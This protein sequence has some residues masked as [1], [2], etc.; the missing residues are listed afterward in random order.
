MQKAAFG[1]LKDVL[2]HSER[3]HFARLK[4]VFKKALRNVL[5]V[6]GI[7]IRLQFFSISGVL[8]GD[9]TRLHYLCNT[10]A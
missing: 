5:T 2:W 6:N 8:F 9:A 10:F 1:T 4:A 3:R 7:L